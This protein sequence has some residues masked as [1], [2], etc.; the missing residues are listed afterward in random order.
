MTCGVLTCQ[1]LSLITPWT[2]CGFYIYFPSRPTMEWFHVK[3]ENML[4]HIAQLQRRVLQRHGQHNRN[5][6]CLH[7]VFRHSVLIIV[8]LI[9]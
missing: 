1:H 7:S 4:W 9:F 6:H 5:Q 8:L 2:G 3:L